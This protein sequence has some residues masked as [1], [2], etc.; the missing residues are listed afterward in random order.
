[1]SYLGPIAQERHLLQGMLPCRMRRTTHGRLRPVVPTR[2]IPAQRG[3]GMPQ[4]DLM[5]PVRV[6]PLMAGDYCRADA[7]SRHRRR[8]G[9]SPA[10]RIRWWAENILTY[11]D[12]KRAAQKATRRRRRGTRLKTSVS[13]PV[14]TQ[15][16]PGTSAQAFSICC[17]VANGVYYFCSSPRGLWDQKGTLA[18]LHLTKK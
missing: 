9:L 2:R 16:H 12:A 17:S 8:Q 3:M 5:L 13:S 18:E 7:H 6:G 1:M 11:L 10:S 4:S 15:F 14:M